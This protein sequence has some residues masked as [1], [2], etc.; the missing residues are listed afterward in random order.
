MSREDM[1]ALL[2]EG[3]DVAAQFL[4]KSGEF[5]PF[6]LVKTQS[7]EV[8]HMQALTEAGRPHSRTVRELLEGSLRKGREEQQYGTVA[9]VSNVELT[10]RESED[11]SDAISLEIDD[12][13]SDPILCYVPYKIE[14]DCL[15][16]G[17]VKASVG[18]R[19]VFFP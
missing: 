17:E 1:N 14:A 6:A 8:R 3:I 9:I 5:Y 18:Q 4:R 12:I 10:N 7:G 2:N 11:K 19:I 15:N 16:L 13:E